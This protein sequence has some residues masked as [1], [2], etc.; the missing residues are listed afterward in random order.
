MRQRGLGFSFVRLLPKETGVRP[1]I[2]LR[3]KQT[4]GAVLQL[5]SLLTSYLIGVG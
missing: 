5:L 1:I 3:R 2:N 4:V